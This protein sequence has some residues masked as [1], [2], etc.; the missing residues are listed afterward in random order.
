MRYSKIAA[1]YLTAW[2]LLALGAGVVGL[3]VNWNLFYVYFYVA[4]GFVGV[5]VFVF[6][7][8]IWF[9]AKFILGFVKFVFNSI[10]SKLE[11]LDKIQDAL[12]SKED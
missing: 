9:A 5:T 2:T 12:E 8:P 7:N 1:Y 4:S 6:L 10:S 11:V 3:A